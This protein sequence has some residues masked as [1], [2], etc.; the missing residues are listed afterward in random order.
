MRQQSIVMG[1]ELREPKID[2]SETYK[3]VLMSKRVPHFKSE[4]F[5]SREEEENLA[6]GPK[7]V[8]HK[9]RLAD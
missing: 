3:P 4:S 8:R 9:D 7:M 6:M 1:L 2:C 5:K